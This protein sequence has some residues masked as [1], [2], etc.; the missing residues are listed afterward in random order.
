MAVVYQAKIGPVRIPAVFSVF[1]NLAFE[2]WV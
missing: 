1:E 2:N